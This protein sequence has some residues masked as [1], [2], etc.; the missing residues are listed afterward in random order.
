MRACD[1]LARFTVSSLLAKL[2]WRELCKAISIFVVLLDEDRAL[3]LELLDFAPLLLLEDLAEL[4]LAVFS[5]LLEDFAEELELAT[6]LE[7]F[8]ELELATLLELLV[9]LL[10]ELAT[11]SLLLLDFAELELSTSLLLDGDSVLLLTVMTAF[12]VAVFFLPSILFPST[13][14]SIV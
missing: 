6:L 11:F 7:D 3:S 8:A 12:A 9:V 5:L 13:V 1:V 2:K 4:E 10:E 14:N